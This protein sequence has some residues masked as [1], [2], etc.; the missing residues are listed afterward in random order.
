MA[1]D[2]RAVKIKKAEKA[3]AILTYNYEK[4]RLFIRE[5]VK[6]EEKAART[7]SSRNRGDKEE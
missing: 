7:R 3:A 4:E 6:V 2:P 5:F 1:Y